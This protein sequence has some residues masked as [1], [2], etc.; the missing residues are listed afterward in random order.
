MVLGINGLLLNHINR[1]DPPANV[2]REGF[3]SN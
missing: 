1:K 2:V 3:E